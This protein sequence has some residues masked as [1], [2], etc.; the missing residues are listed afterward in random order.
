MTCGGSVSSLRADDV[1]ITVSLFKYISQGVTLGVTS[2]VASVT[3]VINIIKCATH[4]H[5]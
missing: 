1:G 2:L 5:S 3:V 4:S